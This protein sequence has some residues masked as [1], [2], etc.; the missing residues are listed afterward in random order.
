MQSSLVVS[1]SLDASSRSERLAVAY[2]E[3]LA[4]NGVEAQLLSLKDYPLPRFDDSEAI[5]LDASYRTLHEAAS[6]ASGLVLAGPVY[7]WGS[8]AELKR[9]V[10]VV[11][12]TPPGGSVRSPFFDKIVTFVNAAGLPHSYMAFSG[13]AVSMVVDYKCILNPYN[14]YA[15]ER[16][17]SG[18]ILCDEVTKRLRKSASVMAELQ[19][20]L[21]KRNYRSEWEI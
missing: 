10:E 1:S 19:R 7:N 13:L 16:H 11:G 21:A 20:L 6:R 2:V 8:C 4:Q 5:L 12:T 14:V 18:D 17:W 9:F 15:H 3:A